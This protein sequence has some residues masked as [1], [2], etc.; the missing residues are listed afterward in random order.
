MGKRNVSH[1]DYFRN[2]IHP[3]KSEAFRAGLPGLRND[4]KNFIIGVLQ[5]KVLSI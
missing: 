5:G 4:L 2:P 3:L 1:D